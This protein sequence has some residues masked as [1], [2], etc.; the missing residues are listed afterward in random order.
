MTEVLLVGTC[1]ARISSKG[2]GASSLSVMLSPVTLSTWL[3]TAGE[4]AAWPPHEELGFDISETSEKT[5]FIGTE[6]TPG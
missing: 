3:G 1:P 4:S 5:H 2:D 6:L